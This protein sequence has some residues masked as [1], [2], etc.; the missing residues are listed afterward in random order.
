MWEPALKLNNIDG[1][2]NKREKKEEAADNVCLFVRF[3]SI[4]RIFIFARR[5]TGLLTVD[6]PWTPN[7]LVSWRT[8]SISVEIVHPIHVRFITMDCLLILFYLLQTFVFGLSYSKIFQSNCSI[9][10]SFVPICY[11]KSIFTSV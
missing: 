6:T 11:L 10:L 4:K 5:K 9:S 2:R 1:E 8:F 7:E 3:T